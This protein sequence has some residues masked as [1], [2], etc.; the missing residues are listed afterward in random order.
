[1]IINSHDLYVEQTGPQ[2][3]PAVVLLHHGLG[4]VRAWRGQIQALAEAGHRVIAYDRWGYGGSDRRDGLDLPAF[5]TDVSDLGTL[6]DQLGIRRAALVGHSDGGTIALYYAAR[7]PARVRCLVTVAAHIYIEPKME[8]AFVNLQESFKSDDRFRKGMKLAHGD[9]YESVFQHWF[10]GWYRIESLSWDLRSVLGSIK[11]PALIVQG[12][13]DEHASPQH[14]IDI[15]ESI[16][17]AELWII[18]GV[19]HMVPQE[20][21]EAFNMKIVQFL[22]LN[23]VEKL[24]GK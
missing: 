24:A 3:G 20:C 23:G 2:N 11:C 1:M 15:A 5:T 16:P 21:T 18:P 13:E 22:K 8:P 4:S 19:K 6:L 9:K 12:D 10:D 7:Y 17:G 14:A